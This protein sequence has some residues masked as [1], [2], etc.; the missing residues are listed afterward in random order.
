MQKLIK[1]P[2]WLKKRLD[3]NPDFNFTKSVLREFSINTVCESA[4]CPN[5][6]DCFSKKA[7]TFL[8]LG[9]NCTRDC[10]FCS[11]GKG[12]AEAPEED[13][14][15]R[16]A[17]AVSTLSLG[18]VVITSVTRD[19]L[20]DGGSGQF[21]RVIEAIRK[22][23]GKKIG[24][25]VLVPDFKGNKADIKRVA[26]ANPDI[27][28]HN[29]ET[30]PRLYKKIRPKADYERSINVLRYAKEANPLLTTK[31]GFMLGLGETEEEIKSLMNDLRA[32][33]CDMLAIGQ[34]LRP[35][36]A[37]VEV[38]EFIK[39]DKFSRFKEL[40]YSLGFKNVQSG[41]FVR[42]SYFKKR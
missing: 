26:G 11:V 20:S 24:I 17:E 34:Y 32:A 5:I 21:V 18:R 41:P 35:S 9:N 23:I 36:A 31:S 38:K 6:F 4:R 30:A 13:E 7:A 1:Q 2:A 8:I 10:A 42:S 29:V 14:P 19:D 16:A 22:R 3:N 28:G 37:Q 33:S 39:P 27:F 25:E 15:D 12:R 40:G